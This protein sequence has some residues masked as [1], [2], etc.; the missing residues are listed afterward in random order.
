MYTIRL[1]CVCVYGC[2]FFDAVKWVNDLRDE[3]VLCRITIDHWPQPNNS[4]RQQQSFSVHSFSF[5]FFF[6]SRRDSASAVW[7]R[8]QKRGREIEKGTERQENHKPYF[9][10]KKI[11][12][13]W[14]S[15]CPLNVTLACEW[16][17]VRNK[18]ETKLTS[19]SHQRDA[20]TDHTILLCSTIDIPE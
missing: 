3:A 6:T 2:V 14:C 10:P 5:F 16:T 13:Y 4:E 11:Q 8:E 19:P 18:D 15:R 17:V 9:I 7:E 12:N 1:C 20:R